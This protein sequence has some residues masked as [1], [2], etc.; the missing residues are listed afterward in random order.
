[1]Q[2]RLFSSFGLPRNQHR[3]PR[4]LT[5][6]N[7]LANLL[8]PSGAFTRHVFSTTIL[9]VCGALLIAGCGANSGGGGGPLGGLAGGP[10][11]E[12]KV[13]A[14]AGAGALVGSAAGGI[15]GA[16]PGSYG[17]THSSQRHLDCHSYKPCHT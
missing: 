16:V 12:I 4:K 2:D 7:R 3:E 14:A 15:G 17:E 5:L 8:S 11:G 13:P 6:M 9:L 1:M 10:F